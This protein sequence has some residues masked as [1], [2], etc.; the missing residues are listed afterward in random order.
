MRVEFTIP[1]KTGTGLNSREFWAARA[2]RVKRERDATAAV[3]LDRAIRSAI[4]GVGPPFIVNLMRV[5]PRGTLLD[6]DNLRGSLKAVRDA[7]AKQLGVDDGSALITFSYGQSKGPWGVNVAIAGQTLPVTD[8][9]G[10][11]RG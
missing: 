7:V 6:D 10:G 5:K 4:Q 8:R 3:M 1:L 2:K 11:S 9:I